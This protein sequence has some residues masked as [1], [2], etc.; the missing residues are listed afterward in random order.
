MSKV[1]VRQP[2]SVGRQEA[3]SRLG[4]FS[5]MLGKYGVKLNWNGDKAAVQGFGVSGELAVSDDAVQ[6][7]LALGMM[8][9]AAGVDATRLQASIAKRLAEAFAA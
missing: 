3:K 8:A 6:V 4:G 1:S 7:D 5:E 2:H 9:R